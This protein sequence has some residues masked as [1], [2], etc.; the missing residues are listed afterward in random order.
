[1]IAARASAQKDTEEQQLLLN[2]YDSDGDGLL[3][4]CEVL[5]FAKGEYCLEISQAGLERIFQR[6]LVQDNLGF[7]C[8]GNA[9]HH[10][11]I[12]VGIERELV[13]DAERR[14]E[15][16]RH[17]RWLQQRRET[18]PG[19]VSKVAAAVKG[20][21]AQLAAVVM[22]I[23][24]L[25]DV[26][27]DTPTSD[28]IKR[29]EEVNAAL[30]P[31]EVEAA[32]VHLSAGTIAPDRQDPGLLEFPG[33]EQLSAEA[34]G[35]ITHADKLIARIKHI[36]A[37]QAS[38]Y[39]RACTR[40]REETDTGLIA[41][42]ITDVL[43]KHVDSIEQE[44]DEIFLGLRC[45]SEDGFS[46]DDFV[47]FLRSRWGDSFFPKDSVVRWVNEHLGSGPDALTCQALLERALRVCYRALRPAVMTEGGQVLRRL[48]VDE[49]IELCARP[50]RDGG[51][52]VARIRGRAVGD[53]TVG[54]ITVQGNDGT[55]FLGGRTVAVR[56]GALGAKPCQA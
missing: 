20:L 7:P 9:C 47:T 51:S 16:E 40:S 35:L 48:E 50:R 37:R 53:G 31:L 12:A 23:E 1:V 15:A 22:K 41:K 17:R 2:K 28:I 42:R 13:R 4:R 43:R 46:C 56:E 11:K 25:P 52:G 21:D 26:N 18:W 6:G 3:S 19:E 44:C 54:S 33:M 30:K 29:A 14:A 38:F 45:N 27:S 49:V 10:L 8:R 24:R 32:A 36:S 34:S 55:R 39:S 5:D